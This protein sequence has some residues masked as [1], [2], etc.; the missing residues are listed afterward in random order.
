MNES[1]ETYEFYLSRL[2][3]DHLVPLNRNSAG[4]EVY[5]PYLDASLIK[6]YRQIP[7]FRKVS[8]IE[9]K[10]VMKE[11]ARNLKIPNEIINRNKYGF[12]DAFLTKNKE[13]IKILS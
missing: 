7:L 9:R 6:T 10:I 12:C 11:L 3:P 1:T 2:Y 5:L 8:E 4:V 13:D